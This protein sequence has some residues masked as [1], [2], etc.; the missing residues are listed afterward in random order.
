[1]IK[2]IVERIIA[3]IP[4]D[5]VLRVAIDECDRFI[6]TFSEDI[7]MR[8]K[9]KIAQLIRDEIDDALPPL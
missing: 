6:M 3:N 2:W 5:H 7:S 9:V 8:S 1:M 4:I